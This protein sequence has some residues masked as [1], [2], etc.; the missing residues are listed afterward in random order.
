MPALVPPMPQQAG[1]DHGASVWPNF[2]DV[3]DNAMAL[4]LALDVLASGERRWGCDVRRRLREHIYTTRDVQSVHWV[5]PQVDT[6]LAACAGTAAR[7]A[8]QQGPPA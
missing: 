7:G 6:A 4:A 5:L 3:Q 8:A 2:G 1:E